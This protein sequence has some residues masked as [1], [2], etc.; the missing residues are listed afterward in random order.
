MSYLNTAAGLA[1]LG[2]FALGLSFSGFV[3]AASADEPASITDV[4]AHGGTAGH[5]PA[6]TGGN[7]TG[8]GALLEG[9]CFQDMPVYNKAGRFVGRGMVNTC[10]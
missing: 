2:A 3:G 6:G 7:P 9:S 4:R 5:G 1:A 8:E 10:N